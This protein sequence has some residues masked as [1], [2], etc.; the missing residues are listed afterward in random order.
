VPWFTANPSNILPVVPY[1]PASWLRR[2]MM[3]G[4]CHHQLL[5]PGAVLF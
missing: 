5:L 1:A 3:I 2:P 4:K